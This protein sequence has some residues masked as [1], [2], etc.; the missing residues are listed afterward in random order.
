MPAPL[1]GIAI[2]AAARLAAKKAA[3]AGAKKAAQ[4]GVKKAVKTGAAKAAKSKNPVVINSA[5]RAARKAATKKR[6]DEVITAIRKK[7][8]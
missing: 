1:I 4:V 7:S 3:Q 5:E 8:K 2:G 6:A